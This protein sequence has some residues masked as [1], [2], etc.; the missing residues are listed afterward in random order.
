MKTYSINR[1]AMRTS[2]AVCLV[3]FLWVPLLLIIGVML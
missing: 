2:A 3:W 1:R